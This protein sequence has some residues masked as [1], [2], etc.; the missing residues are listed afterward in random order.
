M[1]ILVTGGARSGK[2]SFA[3]QYAMRV[4]SRGI[5]LATC[6]PY[7]DEMRERTLKHQLDRDESGFNWET[8]EEAYDAASLLAQFARQ[9][10]LELEEGI[11][12]PVVLLDCLTLWLTNWLMLDEQQPP[13]DKRLAIEIENL[14]DAIHHYPF[15]LLMVTNE[16]GDGIVPA[17]PLGRIF[18]DEAGRL[19]QRIA[20]ICDRVFL[21]TAGIP[22]ELKSQAFRWEQL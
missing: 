22:L 19:N 15:P 12:P 13:S 16:V 4:A 11:E 3:E 5:Y 6:Q 14:I 2:S 17:Y 21:V 7:D 10:A 1:A 18:R 20:S 8:R 9:F